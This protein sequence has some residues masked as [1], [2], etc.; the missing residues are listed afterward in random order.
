VHKRDKIFL[1]WRG[2]Q[3]LGIL[4]VRYTSVYNQFIDFMSS[5]SCWM[6]G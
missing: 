2:N 1:H 3:I 4:E 5:K 6:S